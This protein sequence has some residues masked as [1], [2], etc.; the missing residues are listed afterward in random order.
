MSMLLK[1]AAVGTVLWYGALAVYDL[2]M[3]KLKAAVAHAPMR[4]AT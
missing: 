1:V 4:A 2:P 3:Q